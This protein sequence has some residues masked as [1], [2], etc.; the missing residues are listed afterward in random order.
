MSRPVLIDG[1]AGKIAVHELAGESDNETILLVCHATGFL[2]R[3]YRAFA[4]ELR[5][6]ARTVALD[7][8]AHG[9]SD[10]PQTPAEFAWSAMA[11]DVR[12]VIDHLAPNPDSLHGF[13]H[14]MGAAAL[15]ET[16]R[17]SP[18]TFASAMAFEPIVPPGP[19]SGPDSPIV[20]AARGRLRSFPTYADALARYAARPP[21]NLFRADVLSDYVRHGFAEVDDVVTLKCTPENEATTYGMAGEIHLGV[22]AEIDLAVR[23]AKSGDG[24]FPAQL[25][26]EV[27]RQ[28]PNGVLVDFPTLTHFGPLQDPVIVAN[29]MRSLI[30][31]TDA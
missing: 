4:H 31:E 22:I 28:L 14:S 19:I 12:A 25:A 24:A 8:R 26:N 17:R 29:A 18:G 23:V 3:V 6:D 27:A 13:G 10:A 2:G 30:H 9:D 7:F 21:L 5:D 1:N 15:L 20:K 16:E 11:D